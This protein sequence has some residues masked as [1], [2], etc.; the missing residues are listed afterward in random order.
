MAKQTNND[1]DA[2]TLKGRNYNPTKE[3]LETEYGLTQEEY[4]MLDGNTF[5]EKLESLAKIV[6]RPVKI[7]KETDDEETGK[8][9][10]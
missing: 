7:V 10:P 6:M 2:F 8:N 5:E 9:S 1:R 3:E 4:D